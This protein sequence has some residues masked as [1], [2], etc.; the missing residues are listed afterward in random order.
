V[1]D[2]AGAEIDRRLERLDESRSSLVDA[3]PS[4][5][6]EHMQALAEALIRASP[7]ERARFTETISLR[8]RMLVGRGLWRMEH[9]AAAER[10]RDLLLRA[11]VVHAALDRGRD[12]RDTIVW[13]VIPFLE[14]RLL[15]VDPVALFDEAA[16]FAEPAVAATMRTTGRRTDITVAA[17]SPVIEETPEGP[18][19]ANLGSDEGFLAQIDRADFGSRAWLIDEVRRREPDV[20]ERLLEWIDRAPG[21][22]DPPERS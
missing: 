10:S 14:A 2:E 3:S 1:P 7:E 17:F 13:C 4:V 12:Y 21:R 11:L 15:A 22:D 20:P 8:H 9:R 19:P 16:A 6:D 5:F 18:R